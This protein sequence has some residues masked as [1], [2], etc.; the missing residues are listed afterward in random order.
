MGAVFELE[1]PA[2]EKLVLLAMAD[3]ARDDGTGCYPSIN[4]LAKKTS[5]TKRGV[6]KVI[7]R[8]R[9]AQ[10]VIKGMM[11]KLGT[12]EYTLTLCGSGGEQGSLVFSGR[13]VNGK[14]KRGERQ[15]AKG[16]NQ[17]PK[18]GELGSPEP[19][20]TKDLIKNRTGSRSRAGCQD[21][22]SMQS[23][24]VEETER[25]FTSELKKVAQNESNASP[26]NGRPIEPL[27]TEL[28]EGIFRKKIENAFFDLQR[29]PFEQQIEACVQEAVTSL[30]LNR[31]RKTMHLRD[32]DVVKLALQKL[33]VGI[34]TLKHVK[35]F[36]Q[37]RA[38]VTNAI[39]RR[40]ADAA[41]EL[42]EGMA[43][44]S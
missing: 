19:S 3:H 17:V 44:A 11:T 34:E 10:L 29:E 36:S 14:P 37:R 6:Y 40:V 2:T 24:P 7:K 35:D 28:Y 25:Q 1:I 4:R 42:L 21:T 18:T 8:L 39:A 9:A 20:E 26:G 27:R 31:T 12:I 13:G 22:E 30:V 41:A 32:T 23:E 38:M 16:V 15:D 43:V 33:G 5:L